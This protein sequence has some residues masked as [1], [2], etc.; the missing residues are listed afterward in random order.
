MLHACHLLEQPTPSRG[1]LPHARSGAH[2]VVLCDLG[3]RAQASLDDRVVAA[4]WAAG[5]WVRGVQQ[6]AV[7]QQLHHRLGV[8]PVGRC[9]PISVC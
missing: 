2:L 9:M 4:H 5:Q 1:S 7:R 6:E 3:R 8:V